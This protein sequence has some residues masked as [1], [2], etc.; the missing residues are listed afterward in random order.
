MPVLYAYFLTAS[1][2]LR[3]RLIEL[4]DDETGALGTSE[5]ALLLFA[6]ATVAIA[7]G[8]FLISYVAGLQ[9]DIPGQ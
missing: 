9:A 7:F 1:Q 5:L 2:R 3:D 6:V 8:A 4:H